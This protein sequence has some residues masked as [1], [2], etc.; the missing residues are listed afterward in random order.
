MAWHQHRRRQAHQGSISEEMAAGEKKK[1][2]KRH[3]NRHRKYG[4]S[5]SEKSK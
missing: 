1:M 5:E 3:H 2:K 4:E